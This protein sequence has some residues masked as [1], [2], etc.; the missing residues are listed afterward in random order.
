MI[1]HHG[2]SGKRVSYAI[3]RRLE[4]HRIDGLLMIGGWDGYQAAYQIF[5]RRDEFP[6]FNIPIVC[7]PASIDNNLP[8]SQLSIGADTALNCIISDVDKIKQSALFDLLEV[9]HPR[10]RVF[11]GNRQKKTI[12]DYFAYPFIAKIPRGSA[13][14]R[15]SASAG[16]SRARCMPRGLRP[17]TSCRP[18]PSASSSRSISARGGGSPGRST[19]M[20]R[21]GWWTVD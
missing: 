21:A 17:G 2:E 9:P 18:G 19:A 20:I 11:Y 16:R 6:T 10:T 15:R 7:L 8:G 5:R 1:L 12:R 3:A 4:T 13:M 14:R